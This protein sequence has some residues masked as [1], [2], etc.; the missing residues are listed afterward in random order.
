MRPSAFGRV[1]NDRFESKPFRFPGDSPHHAQRVKRFQV[2]RWVVVSALLVLLGGTLFRLSDLAEAIELPLRDQALTALPRRPA[3]A[4][5][6][7]AIDEPSLRVIG[8]W[9]W[10]R[11]RIAE[12]VDGIRTRGARTVV[13]DTLL[14][15]PREGDAL[16]SAAL[17]KIPALAVAVLKED[18]AW[19]TPAPSLSGARYAHGNFELDHD[20]IL[21]RFASTKQS[22][23]R[24]MIA[25]SLAAA[26][27]VGP[28]TVPV[29]RSLIP[30]LRTS[31]G[32]IPRVSAQ[33]LL[34]GA[35]DPSLLRDR[36]VFVGPT[37]LAL[38]DRVL[39]SVSRRLPEPG[40]T[41]HAAATESILR[42][43]NV[44][45]ISP[46][47]TGAWSALAT[48]L[49]VGFR[50]SRLAVIVA[51]LFLAVAAIAGGITL[52]ATRNVVIPFAQLILTIVLVAFVVEA[53]RNILSLRRTHEAARRMETGL[54]LSPSPSDDDVSI[55]LNQIATKLAAERARDIESKRVLAHELKTPLASMRGLT[56][57]LAEFELTPAERRRVT[58][59]LGHEAEKLQSMVT[60]LLDLERLTMRDFAVETAVQDLAELSER[61]VEFLRAGT[62]RQL[63][64]EASSAVPV[65]IDAQL[66]ERVVDNLVG[67]ALK[68]TP[69]ESAV[70]VRVRA[71]DEVAELAVEDRG[72]GIPAPERERIF[73]RFFRGTTAGGTEGLGL[74]LA[75][76]GEVAR[77]HGGSVVVE[78]AEGG[79][80]RFRFILPLAGGK[81]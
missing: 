50:R 67:N 17:H 34:R 31:P 11:T 46:V 39:T 76:V 16:L 58:T 28:A 65:R 78:E 23:D 21:R 45:E 73:Q 49:I 27:T 10:S 18:G 81:P 19:L 9:P 63:K 61:R 7:V 25:L 59:L 4:T 42:G 20:G 26:A 32:D 5:V 62:D 44:R 74:G 1:W 52:L 53:L 12:L 75:L 38:G 54:G 3:T 60:A 69:H 70:T 51:A 13:L 68:Y 24:S 15:E 77:W 33:A 22:A 35:D 71:T 47:A 57:L 66:I 56:G 8:P 43:E 40:V 2:D 14:A 55:R 36:I 6:V 29:G 80:A 30:A 37:A 64:I 79:G 41:V 48:G 72:P